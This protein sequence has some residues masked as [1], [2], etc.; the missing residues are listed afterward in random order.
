MQI[1]Y[2]FVILYQIL[3]SSGLLDVIMTTST[4]ASL[5]HV[6]AAI[7]SGVEKHY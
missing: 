4:G 2:T 6:T 5:Q 3:K 7:I 1:F